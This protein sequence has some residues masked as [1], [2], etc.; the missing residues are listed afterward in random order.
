M[1]RTLLAVALLV[2]M[3]ALAALRPTEV[4]HVLD[5]PDHTRSVALTL[6]A[7]SG[8]FDADLLRFLALYRIQ[9]TVFVTKRWISR[10]PAGVAMLR[11]NPDL[12][13]IENH[14]ARHVPAVIG[15]GRQVYGIE[16][17]PDLEHLDREVKQGAEAVERLTGT[18]PRWYRGATGEYDPAALERIAA[19]GFKVAGF[20]VN[21]DDGA[22]LPRETILA[23]LKRVRSGDIIIAHLNKPDSDTGEA[24]AAGLKDLLE[25]GYRFV[26]LSD[27]P[28][29]LATSRR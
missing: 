13:Q 8:A 21:A 25:K 27:T 29:R 17:L 9:A 26:K 19:L 23:R 7:C 22:T 3:L 6:D 11:A 24:L 18:P 2:P 28:V 12:F 16:G 1:L 5:V 14:G 20:S 10:N 15:P 4:R